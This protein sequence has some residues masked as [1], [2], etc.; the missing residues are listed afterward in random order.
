MRVTYST[1]LGFQIQVPEHEIP[2]RDRE[3]LL[4]ELVKQVPVCVLKQLQAD[5]PTL[6]SDLERIYD[7]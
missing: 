5:L 2:M 4:F 1:L 6:I 3:A 7:D